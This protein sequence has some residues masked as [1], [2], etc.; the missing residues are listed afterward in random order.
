MNSGT[1]NTEAMITG[2]HRVDSDRVEVSGWDAKENF[3]VVRTSLDWREH[4]GKTVA[5]H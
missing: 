2:A 4:E 1:N 3:F 5:R